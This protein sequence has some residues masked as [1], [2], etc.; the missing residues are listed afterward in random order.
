M[1]PIISIVG[2]SESG[3]T[4]LLEEL[5]A[6]LK[7]RGY[8][9]AVI[10]HSGEDLELDTAKKDTWR[11]SQAGSEISAICSGQKLAIFKRM[12]Y[13]CSP[14]ELSRFVWWDYD[15]VLTE[16]F[17]KSSYPKIEVHR[18]V[19]GKDLVSPPQQ[20]LAVVTDEPLAVDVPQFSRNDINK[21][22]DLIEKT[23][24]SQRKEDDIGLLINGDYIPISPA[25][26]NL[27]A[28]TLIAMV[29]SL[30]DTSELKSLAIS[31][32]RKG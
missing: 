16:G 6:E 19:K 25:L 32:R 18:G 15:F 26:K 24:L 21:I 9:V 4:T 7:R 27:L 2:R 10:K 28:R 29:S 12:E 17:K 31:F 23:I 14:D 1:H 5:I 13:D 20:L 3:K 30:K 8:R 11:F 22:A